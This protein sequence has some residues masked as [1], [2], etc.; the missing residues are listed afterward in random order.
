MTDPRHTSSYLP[1]QL[2]DL[3]LLSRNL[4]LELSGLRLGQSY[5]RHQSSAE[6]YL[7][8]EQRGLLQSR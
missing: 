3:T 7:L 1:T 2:R 6:F 8:L 5:R 4:W